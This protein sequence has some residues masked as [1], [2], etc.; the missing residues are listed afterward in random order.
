VNEDE[1]F[2]WWAVTGQAGAGKSRLVFELCHRLPA[3]WFG[4]F[5][6]DG[7]TINDMERFDL[8]QG[9]YLIS[10]KMIFNGMH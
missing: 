5:L 10:P 4:F 8:L 9:V 6:N 1:K 7:T 3:S 2:S